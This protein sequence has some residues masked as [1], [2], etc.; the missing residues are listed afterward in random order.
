M[1]QDDALLKIKNKVVNC[2]KCSLYKTRKIPV[3]GQG[4]HDA[5]IMFIGEA[6]GAN[7]DKTGFPFCGRAGEIIDQLLLSIGLNRKEIYIANIL[8]CRPPANRN[9]EKNEIDACSPYLEKQIKIIQPKL[10]CTMG[11]FATAFIFKKYGLVDKIQGISKLH[12]QLQQTDKITI[13]PLYHPAVATYNANMFDVLKND[14]QQ[15]KK[16]KI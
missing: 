4:N 5:D 11:N 1:K 2:Q 9:P 3:I 15:I 8:K 10:I 14:F 12:G 7:E 13:L 6:P 16:F